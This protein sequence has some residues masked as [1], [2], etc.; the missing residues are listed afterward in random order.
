[1]TARTMVSLRLES[2]LLERLDRVALER[3][4]SRSDTIRELL[5]ASLGV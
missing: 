1:M 2:P 3:H 5:G 4:K